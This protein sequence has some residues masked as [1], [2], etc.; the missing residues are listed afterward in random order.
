[1]GKIHNLLRDDLSQG[2]GSQVDSEAFFLGK[3]AAGKISLISLSGGIVN[4]SEAFL[5]IP[6][7]VTSGLDHS[8]TDDVQLSNDINSDGGDDMEKRLAVLETE[9]VHIKTDVSEL[10]KSVSTIETTVNSITKIWRLSW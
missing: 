4:Y 6:Q 5:Q 8:G 9:F 7:P 3:I 2:F 1:M 10:K